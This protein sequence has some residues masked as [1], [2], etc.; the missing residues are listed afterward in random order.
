MKY[1]GTL[2]A[3]LVTAWGTGLTGLFGI[4]PVIAG[5]ILVAIALLIAPA[6]PGWAAAEAPAWRP[7]RRTRGARS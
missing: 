6:R 4:G 1:I 7:T 5:R 3:A 2:I